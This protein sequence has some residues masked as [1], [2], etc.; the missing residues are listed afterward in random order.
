MT[1]HTSIRTLLAIAALHNLEIHQMDVKTAFLYGELEDE[2]YMK[3]PEGFVVPGQEHKVCRLKRSLYGLKQAPLQW[4]M[5]FDEVMLSNGFK[6]N[7]SDKCVY[8][9]NSNNN[10]VIVCLYVDDMLIM[11][12]NSQVIGETK[13]MLSKNFSMKDMGLADVILGIKILR[14]PNGIALTQSHYAEKV[15]KKFNAIDKP[16]AKTP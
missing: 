15:L 9:K 13:R 3:Q 1:K 10:Y 4:N 6:I 7:E 2:I 5:K 14:T 16:I 11:G 12:S 8:V